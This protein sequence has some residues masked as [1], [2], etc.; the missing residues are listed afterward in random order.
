MV[1]VIGADV[2]SA[3]KSLRKLLGFSPPRGPGI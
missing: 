1:T 3:L 2:E